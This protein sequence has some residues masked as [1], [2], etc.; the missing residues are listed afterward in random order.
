MLRIVLSCR[1]RSDGGGPSRAA[2]ACAGVGW[3]LVGSMITEALG[4]FPDTK[5]PTHG[6]AEM[7]ARMIFSLHAY[8]IPSPPTL[9]LQVVIEARQ[10]C[11]RVLVLAVAPVAVRVAA[12]VRIRLNGF[13]PIA[14]RLGENVAEETAPGGRRRWGA[15]VHLVRLLQL[16]PLTN[17]SEKIVAP[18]GMASRR[19]SL[20]RLRS[21]RR[22]RR[23]R[24]LGSLRQRPRRRRRPRLLL[25]RRTRWRPSR[26][27]ASRALWRRWL[28]RRLASRTLWRRWLS[29]RLASRALRRWRPWRLPAD[30][31]C[32]IRR[33]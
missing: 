18:R 7:P 4:L 32:A 13:A 9:V 16:D 1:G 11:A 23:P 2:G 3:A 6:G 30:L 10:G 17:R 5:N 26:R 28:S 12:E 31:R 25:R 22:Q 33:P 8:L 27:L 21:L 20:P 24:R 29:R 14:H 15:I 19:R